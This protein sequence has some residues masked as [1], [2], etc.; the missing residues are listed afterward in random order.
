MA[1]LNAT[2][3]DKLK[4]NLKFLKKNPYIQL[5]ISKKNRIIGSL[6][7]RWYSDEEYI[8]RR[9]NKAFG[10]EL[11]LNNPKAFNEKLQ[12]LKL[13]YRDPEMAICADKYEVRKYLSDKGFKGI[14]NTV[15]AVYEKAGD[16]DFNKLPKRFVL[17][18]T[19]GSGWN[20]ICENN[21]EFS[22]PCWR[23]VL[24]SWL[25]QNLYVYGREWVYKDM[26]P[27]ILCEK[28][29]EIEDGELFD[30]K[31]FCLNGKVEFIQATDNDKKTAR[32]NLYDI[33]WNLMK[34]KYA[35][36]GSPKNIPRPAMLEQMIEIAENLSKPFPFARI[37]L[38]DVNGGIVFGEMTFFP[39]SGFKG[40]YPEKFDLEL[41]EKLLLP[42]MG[43]NSLNR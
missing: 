26:K 15:Y 8:R 33:D 6:L 30:Y 40:F 4:D 32:I 3:I 28:Y 17:K 12:W 1:K 38:Y 2:V 7:K 24:N 16:I 43:S 41:G 13:Y 18:A 39:S 31:F 21:S 23:R 19:H 35:F 25:N 20:I 10:R 9:Y 14:L 22:W 36:I 5:L 29:L 34:E 27:R 11:D 42:K 37:D